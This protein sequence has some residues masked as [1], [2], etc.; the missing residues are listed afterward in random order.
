MNTPDLCDAYAAEIQIA[1]PRL[2]SFGGLA[3][4]SGPIATV[5][6]HEDN[7]KVRELLEQP[8]NGRVLVVDGGGSMRCALLGDRLAALAITNHW[9]GLLIHGCVRDVQVLG[10]LR[11]GVHALAAHP[12]KSDKRGSGEIDVVVEFADVRF[13]PGHWVYADDNGIIVAAR[14]LGRSAA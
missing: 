8:G 10:G 6:C 1:T 4:F 3:A 13:V 7:S 9:Q 12:R 5:R 14:D 11:L 2:R